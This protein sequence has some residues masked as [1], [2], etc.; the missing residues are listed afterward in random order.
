MISGL[1]DALDVGR[2]RPCL[3]PDAEI[4]DRPSRWSGREAIVHAPGTGYLRLS[5]DEAEVVRKLDGTRT[6]AELAA[7]DFEDDDGLAVDDLVALVWDLGRAGLLTRRPVDVYASLRTRL[8]P[9]SVRWR[10]RLWAALREQTLAFRRADVAFTAVY[11]WGGR[12]VLSAPGLALGGVLGVGGVV[13]LIANDR[14]IVTS[15]IG[16]GNALLL[17]VLMLGVLLLHECGHAIAVKR[18]G[19]SV[20]RAG[21]MLY[22][23]HPAFFVDSTDLAFATRRQRA[24]NA[25][26]GPFVEAAVAGAAVLWAAWFEPPFANDL[27]RLAALS[28]FSVALNL[29]PFLELDGYWLLTDLLD[30]PH[31]RAR[32]FALL[33]YD[34][35]DRVRGRRAAFSSVERAVALFGVLGVAS[36]AV[37]LALAY[38][39]WFPL[40][41]RLLG[42]GW[43]AGRPGRVAVVLVVALAAGPLVHFAFGLARGIASWARRISDD[44]RFRVESRWRVEAAEAIA[45]LPHARDLDDAVL[46]DLAGRVRRRRI[47]EGAAVIRQG[48]AS[49]AFFVVRRGSFEV[50]E[51]DADGLE[52][53]IRR[54]SPGESFGELGLLGRRPRTATVRATS[55]SEVFE[56]DAG[57]F[58]RLLA[59]ALGEPTVLPTLGPAL[60]LRALGALRRL[61]LEEAVTV[62][63][64]G[65]WLDAAAGT[66]VVVQGEA[67]DGFYVLV[68]GQAVVERDGVEVVRLRAGDH[69]GEAALLRHAPRNATVRTT[70]P[71]RVLRIDDAT[72]HALV[73]TAISRHDGAPSSTDRSLGGAYA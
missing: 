65:E 66:E 34:L 57:A 16:G 30:T 64:Q 49:D 10:R 51:R 29:V 19:R 70:T 20:V 27:Y 53:L 45:A 35:V 12:Y 41:G 71:A 6:L 47:R 72:F 55:E 56:L 25:I 3:R 7:D 42:A 23:G 43:D 67:G 39:I 11:R 1:Q 40:A 5:G 73:A 68:S 8:A 26:A 59:P 62:A 9:A 48:D 14:P 32:S 4:G 58:G 2:A 63:E 50:V 13:A 17:T 54:L 33:R 37:A 69:F 44:L 15:D 60:E 22:L 52:R 36:T 31:L 46:S 21:F 18:A 38:T 61:S 24:L 28:Y